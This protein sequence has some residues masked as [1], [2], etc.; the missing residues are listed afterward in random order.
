MTISLVGNGKLKEG[1]VDLGPYFNKIRGKMI[2]F[3][4]I[5]LFSAGASF[6]ATR[7]MPSRYTATSTVL[8]KAQS[9]DITPLPKLESYDSTR[10]DYYETKYALM[11]SRVVLENAVKTMKLDNDPDFN[12]GA[13]LD[14]KTRF[15]NAVRN[16]QTNLT[17]TGVRSTQLVSVSMETSSAQKAADI[18]N[19]IAQAFIDYSLQQ[20]QQTLHQAQQWNQKLMDEL[21]DKMVKQQGEIDSWLKQENL[22]TFRG[23]DGYETEQ[24]SIATNRLADATQRR[25]Q[26]QSTWEKIQGQPGQSAEQLLSLPEISDHSQIQDLRIALTQAKR[27]ASDAAKHYGPEHPKYRQAQAQV[28][29]VNGQIRLVLSEL[30]NGLHQKYQIALDDEQHYQQMLD[31]QKE[32]FQQLA[33]KK[34]HYTTLVTALN[35]TEDLYKTLYQRANEQA[36]AEKIAVSDEMIYD[37]ATPPINASKPKRTLLILMVTMMSLGLYVMYLVVSTAMDKTVNS[38]SELKAKTTLNASGEFPLFAH[39]L[40]ASQIFS[41]R[42][43]ADMIHSLRM[44]MEG[45]HRGPLTLMVTS[46]HSGNGS[47]LLAELLA[48]SAGKARKTL[49]IDLDY[50][51]P[52]VSTEPKIGFTQCLLNGS[53]PEGVV[54]PLSEDLSLLPRGELSDSPFLVLTS[55][56]LPA[57]L[58]TLHQRWHTLIFNMP[59]MD[60]AQDC[61]LLQSHV[62]MTLL[63]AK[64]GDQAS[65]IGQMYERLHVEG[66]NSVELVIN[67]VREENL[68]SLEGQRIPERHMSE[69]ISLKQKT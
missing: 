38:M 56:R 44:A 39:G 33:A 31:E 7:F 51:K 65:S 58:E 6:V 29:T 14:A 10:N 20:K 36:L 41:E 35:K 42:L 48:R 63:V 1:F 18:A 34:D 32:N 61:L 49:L 27:D 16:L 50:H 28:N 55:E 52:P 2:W 45:S 30:Q 64:A 59:A 40:N 13:A 4:A 46:V 68:E 47:T 57:L 54:T 66:K 21:K 19:G 24:L 12:G 67:K 3:L 62:D 23:V 9:A 8:F 11:G 60:I 5:A 69:L 26:A 15:N 37:P 17:I 22:L 53:I 43:Y 25:I